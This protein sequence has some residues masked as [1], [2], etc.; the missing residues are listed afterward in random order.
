VLLTTLAACHHHAHTQALDR[1][2]KAL[3]EKNATNRQ[4][5][6]ATQAKSEFL[7]NMSHGAAHNNNQ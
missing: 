3:R 6:R 1:L 7:A 5:L 2:K 4:L